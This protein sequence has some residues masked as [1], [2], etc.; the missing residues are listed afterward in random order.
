MSGQVTRM[1]LV[2]RPVTALQLLPDRAGPA[3]HPSLQPLAINSFLHYQYKHTFFFQS[4]RLQLIYPSIHPVT[5]PTI[6]PS[7]QLFIRPPNLYSIVCELFENVWIDVLTL[8][9][10]TV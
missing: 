5:R 3:V 6:H 4:H 8:F 10:I 9:N 1:D 2:P 7:T